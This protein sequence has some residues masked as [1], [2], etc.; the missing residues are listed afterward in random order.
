MSDAADL[1]VKS[2]MV[3]R[4]LAARLERFAPKDKESPRGKWSANSSPIYPRTTPSE[5][6]R[7]A[8]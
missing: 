4:V 5:P 8:F 7:L 3:V 1:V 6:P 2:S